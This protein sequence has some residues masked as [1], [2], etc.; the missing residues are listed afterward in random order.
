MELKKIN[1]QDNGGSIQE[2]TLEDLVLGKKNLL[3][4]KNASGKSK[5]LAVILNLART[6][7]GLQKAV[8][9]GKYDCIFENGSSIY[10]YSLHSQNSLV[11]L[12]RLTIDGAI[13][14]DRGTDGVGSI[15][16]EKIGNGEKIQFQTP[17]TDIAAVSRRDTIQHAFLEPLFQWASSVRYYPFGTL[18][19]KDSF[20]IFV[21]SGGKV[22]DRDYNAVVGIFKEAVK[23]YGDSFKNAIR[24][25]MYAIGYE[26]EDVGIEKPTSITFEGLMGTPMGLFVK[27]KELPGK[28]D[29]TGMS[30]GMFRVLSLLIQV[31]YFQ[32]KKTASCVLIDDIGEG[33]DFS[34]SCRLIGLLRKKAEDSAV[35]IILSTNDKFVMNEVPLKEWSVLQRVGNRVRIRNVDNA[36]DIFEQFRFTGL[37]N[38]SFLELDIINEDLGEL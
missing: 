16:A 38:F 18:L 28:T 15:F 1:F 36:K 23:E 2:W 14:L 20:A 6:L 31:N 24:S 10:E 33:L 17:T 25:D 5:T 37:S 8:H 22:D 29:Q 27:E 30:Q 7:A 3:V 35:Q 26:I 13:L 19:G 9:S 12:E 21:Q 4:G 32:M 11:I 34:R